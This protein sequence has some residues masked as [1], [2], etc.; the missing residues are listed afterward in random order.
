MAV[1]RLE[2]SGK[3]NI[4]YLSRSI[5]FFNYTERRE[6][7]LDALREYGGELTGEIVDVGD[8]V[9]EI[10]NNIRAY[11]TNSPLPDAFIMES[12]HV[13]IGVVKALQSFKISVPEEISLIGI[14]EIPE[15]MTGGKK[16]TLVRVPH[17]EKIQRAMNILKYEMFNEVENKIK[18]VVYCKLIHGESVLQ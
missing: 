5:S 15:Y 14:D 17:S 1:D 16:L 3:K 11:L 9:S 12:Y 10:A 6:G 7:F 8:T 2:S 18:M 13:S 4:V